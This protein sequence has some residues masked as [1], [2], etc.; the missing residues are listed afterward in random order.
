MKKLLYVPVALACLALTLTA[1][2]PVQKGKEADDGQTIVYLGDTGPVVVRVHVR[3]D[4]RSHRQAW[5]TFMDEVFDYLDV[6]KSGDLAKKE[7]GGA[8]PPGVL[9]S[10]AGGLGGG[11]G[12][13]GRGP[14]MDADRDGVVSRAEFRDYY[15]KSGLSPFQISSSRPSTGVFLVRSFGGS[16]ERP[17]SE[18]L[19]TRLFALLDTDKDG[20][21][22][23]KELEAAPTI[24][25]KLDRDEDEML[26]PGEMAG[27]A[28]RGSS[29][30]DFG[31]VVLAYDGVRP[32]GDTR[33]VLL[34]EGK[35]D[36]VVAQRMLAHYGKEGKQK[37]EAKRLGLTKL[38][39]DED[40]WLDAEELSRMSDLAPDAEIIV[41]LGSRKKEEAFVQIVKKGKTRL[42]VEPSKEGVTLTIDNARVELR[43]PDEQ[44]NDT[45]VVVDA[46][47]RY[48]TLFETADTDKNGYL[49]KKE[50]EA[51]RVFGGLFT[52]MD[53]DNDGMLYLKE[54][55]AYLDQMAKFREMALKGCTSLVIRNEGKG[56]FDLIDADGDGR[57]SVRELRN[58]G[59]ALLKLDQDEDGALAPLE[60]PRSYR[61]SF[62][63]GAAGVSPAS[64]AIAVRLGGPMTEPPAPVR[65]KGPLW[66][67]KM[68]RN[69]DGDV[70][71]AEWLGAEEKF[72]EVDTDRDGLISADEADAYDKKARAKE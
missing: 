72:A 43:G 9:V 54:M 51:N 17:S 67:R 30:S 15:R 59:K 55:V 28:D 20:K 49:D 61:G 4:G 68:D 37:L 14:V 69:R 13:G 11:F 12:G 6:D 66:F 26:T 7:A 27:N 19:N 63:Q 32:G 39:R 1:A 5:E 34:A 29:T 36:R 35:T 40:G 46:N 50:A 33:F 18:A 21:L 62:E 52:A 47:A 25:G 44:K 23:K 71:R 42:K 8:P 56:V 24:L 38:D 65:A 45:R 22:S 10:Q 41:R 60:V 2:A 16:D 57:L 58:A 3:V 64:Q 70:S 48:K 31:D 53:R